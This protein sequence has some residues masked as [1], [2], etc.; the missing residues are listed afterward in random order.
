MKL[1]LDRLKN[2]EAFQNFSFGKVDLKDEQELLN[3]FSKFLPE[4]VINLAAQAGVRN[5]LN[6]PLSYINSN[7]CGF[8]NVLESC[9]HH[10][11]K[12]LIYASSSSVYGKNK[13]LPF[14][15]NQNVDH[16]LAIYGATKK[17]NEL[18]AH[19]YSHLFKLPSTGLRFFTVYGP[20]GRP[21]MALFRFTDA[22]FKGQPISIFNNGFMK[23]DFT[24]IDDVVE[25][26]NIF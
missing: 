17:A 12:H 1:K 24:Y 14:A 6:D 18:F 13:K 16:P 8:M 2:I 26:L 4:V 10:N 23:R 22:I 20:W 7:I 19:S 5:S 15:E 9:R 3:V 11:V 25:S 21:D